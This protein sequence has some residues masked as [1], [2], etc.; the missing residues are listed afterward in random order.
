MEAGSSRPFCCLRLRL[1]LPSPQRA[2]P[3]GIIFRQ[4]IGAREHTP[5]VTARTGE[6]GGG[7]AGRVATPRSRVIKAG[8]VETQP[9]ICFFSFV[10]PQ[11]LPKTGYRQNLPPGSPSVRS[12][13]VG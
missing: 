5:A 10:P 1:T 13:S 9:P 7:K 12:F 8:L 4:A 3:T 6:M 11:R 2:P